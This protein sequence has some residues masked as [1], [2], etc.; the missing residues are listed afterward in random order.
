MRKM[1][2]ANG[3]KSRT[4]LKFVLTVGA[5][6]FFADFTYEGS[7]GII[8]P[9]LEFLGA[10]GTI[11]GAIMGFVHNRSVVGVVFSCVVAQIAAVPFFVK[12]RALRR[13]ALRG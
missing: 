7:R 10:N 1:V 12:V 9:F 3:S 13:V 8:G 4:A 11:V 5:V 2:K 6:S